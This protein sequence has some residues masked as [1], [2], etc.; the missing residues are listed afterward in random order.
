MFNKLKLLWNRKPKPEKVEYEV[1][2]N[3]QLYIET[4]RQKQPFI[5]T[6]RTF[7]P[8]WKVYHWYLVKKTDKYNMEYEDGMTVILRDDIKLIRLDKIEINKIK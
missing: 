8:L 4:H 1:V 5:F 6:N 7:R 3:W 2:K